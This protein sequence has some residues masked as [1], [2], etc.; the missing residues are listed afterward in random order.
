MMMMMITMPGKVYVEGV[1]IM[2][3]A[4]K[5]FNL[6]PFQHSHS[7]TRSLAS[8]A[9]PLGFFFFFVH[10]HTRRPTFSSPTTTFFFFE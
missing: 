1:E 2:R 8:P 6:F 10:M 3:R 5:R 4:L 7:F 9:R